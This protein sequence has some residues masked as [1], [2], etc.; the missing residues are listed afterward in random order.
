MSSTDGI[1]RQINLR[2]CRNKKYESSK[3]LINNTIEQSIQHEQL[4]TRNR[5]SKWGK[6][7]TDA[8]MF[9][10]QSGTSSDS[11][12]SHLRSRR[13]RVHRCRRNPPPVPFRPL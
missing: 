13:S 3:R 5:K 7:A 10:D 12:G 8:L 6:L 2:G 1:R 9:A 4:T 11:S